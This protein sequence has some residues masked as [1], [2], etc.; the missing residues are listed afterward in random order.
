MNGS[1]FQRSKA[2]DANG[3]DTPQS[4]DLAIFGRTWITCRRPFGVVV[5]E[6]LLLRMING[7]SIQHRRLLIIDTLDQV[8]SSDVILARY[9]RRIELD[10]IRAARSHMNAPTAH[11]LDDR[12]VG[13]VDLQHVVDR[14]VG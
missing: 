2:G 1:G 14:N 5:D 4:I 13:Y 3:V 12:T 9:F 11:A 7:Q 6:W 10:V 8:L